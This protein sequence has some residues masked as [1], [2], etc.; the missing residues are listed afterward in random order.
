MRFVRMRQH[1]GEI[2]RFLSEW[3]ENE[4]D[5]ADGAGGS[6]PR[7]GTGLD[8]FGAEAPKFRRPDSGPEPEEGGV[9]LAGDREPALRGF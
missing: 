9:G 1:R 4:G 2:R 8:R 7:A 5:S 3:L 6:S